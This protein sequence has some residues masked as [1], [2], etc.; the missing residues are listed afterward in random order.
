LLSVFFGRRLFFWEPGNQRLR[1]IPFTFGRIEIANADL[2][3]YIF[4]P[5]IGSATVIQALPFI[6]EVRELVDITFRQQHAHQHGGHCIATSP[7]QEVHVWVEWLEPRLHDRHTLAG[8]VRRRVPKRAQH[9]N[10]TVL[11]E[12]G[13]VY[14]LL[15]S[16]HGRLCN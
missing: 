2:D 7:H 15:G 14:R 13:E 10:I 16:T 9:L 3:G 11:V 1:R 12:P 6:A 8:P 5:D 4:S